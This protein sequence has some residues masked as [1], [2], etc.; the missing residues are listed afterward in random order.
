MTTYLLFDAPSKSP[1]LRHEIAEGSSDPVVF[2]EQDGKRIVA[3]PVFEATTFGRRDDIVDEF[4]SFN[5]LGLDEL[6]ADATVEEH[7]IEPELVVRAVQRMGATSVTVPPIFHMLV[8]Q[9]LEHRGIEVVVDPR[10]WSQ[11]RRRKT[12]WELEGAERA[13]RAAEVAML[14]AASMLRRSDATADGRLRF[15]GEILTAEW[16][17]EMMSN[18]LSAQGAESETIL[19]QCG[20]VAL[21]GRDPGTGPIPPD[22]SCIIDCC[23]RD[24]RTGAH[25]DMTRTFVAGR[26]SDELVRLHSDVRA[27]LD[28]AVQELKPGSSDAFA[29]VAE[30]LHSRGHATQ[31]HPGHGDSRTSRGFL[32]ALGHG[33]GLEVH[34]RPRLGRRS[35]PLAAGDVVAV[36]PGLYY[37]GIGGVRL[38]DTVLVTDDGYERFTDPFPYDL[39]P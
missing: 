6:T 8:A 12:P 33:V 21:T 24:R 10:A 25:T 20:D 32:H 4:W 29:K 16:L 2:I 23:P 37:P 22:T 15:E 5:D 18:E 9:L 3:G 34:E 31:L 14:T 36:E 26:P 1:E 17:R 19:V 39:E 27:A 38:E 30:F 11:R 35:D 13:Q 28:I 7:M